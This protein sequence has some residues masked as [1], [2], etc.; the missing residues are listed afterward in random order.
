MTQPENLALE[1]SGDVAEIAPSAE[2]SSKP[3]KLGN[4]ANIYIVARSTHYGH[5]MSFEKFSNCGWENVLHFSN[6]G[7]SANLLRFDMDRKSKV[8]HVISAYKEMDRLETGKSD[9]SS[10]RQLLAKS[11]MN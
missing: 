5:E 8:K 6:G 11:K 9:V 10:L 3:S 7:I 1:T 4:L 2:I